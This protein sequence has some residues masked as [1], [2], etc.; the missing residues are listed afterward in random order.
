MEQKWRCKKPKTLLGIETEASRDA[1]H[2]QEQAI[3][4]AEG[5]DTVT[6]CQKVLAFAEVAP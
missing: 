6:G 3:C 4:R 5:V 1:R 2:K